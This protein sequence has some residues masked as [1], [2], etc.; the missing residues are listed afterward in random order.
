MLS[1]VCPWIIQGVIRKYTE[2]FP[3]DIMIRKL[4][5]TLNEVFV[6]RLLSSFK[7]GVFFIKAESDLVLVRWLAFNKTW[8]TDKLIST[9]YGI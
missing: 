2:L 4:F 6:F 5:L 9:S 3:A 1:Y 7:A 8:L